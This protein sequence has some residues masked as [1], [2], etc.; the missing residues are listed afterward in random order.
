MSTIRSDFGISALTYSAI[1]L[2]IP[3]HYE[4]IHKLNP[5]HIRS[6]FHVFYFPLNNA[7]LLENH[8]EGEG[9]W[10]TQN[11][12][13]FAYHKGKEVSSLT[14]IAGCSYIFLLWRKTDLW[15]QQTQNASFQSL[16]SSKI[17]GV[18]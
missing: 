11:Q 3:Y 2:K 15:F 1:A 8:F 18:L 16:F 4:R 13:S 6:Q 5:K 7:H 10:V 9:F 17:L 12:T 14:P